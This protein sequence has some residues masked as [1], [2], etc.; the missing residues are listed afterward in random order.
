MPLPSNERPCWPSMRWKRSN[1]RG[2]SRLGMPLPVSLT[3]SSAPRAVAARRTVDAALEGE[4]EGVGEEVE[5]DL[6]PHVPIDVDRL[7]Q[8]LAGDVEP[9][10]RT[11]AGRT[12]A[13]RQLGR[14]P[15]KLG[16]LVHRLGAARLDAREVEQRV[17]ELEQ[18]HA[19]AVRHRRQ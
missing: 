16:R 2:S 19:V 18:A 6:L 5:D 8:R 12:E 11:L 13:R 7:R 17:D 4:L 15:G 10:P 9:E 1:R 3:R 14:E